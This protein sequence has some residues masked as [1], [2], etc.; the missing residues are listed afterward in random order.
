VVSAFRRIDKHRAV[1]AGSGLV[2]VVAIQLLLNRQLY[3]SPLS[4]GYGESGVLFSASHV[5][6]NAG[7]F[8][9]QA[10]VTFGPILLGGLIIGMTVARRDV[11][12]RV[13]SISVAVTMPY[14]FY[15]PFDHWETL[16]YLLP[17]T[18]LLLVL[19]AAGLMWIAKQPRN[20]HLGRAVAVALVA[21]I[22]LRSEALLRKSS[23]WDI[24]SAEARYPLAGQWL[25][26]NTP[27][28]SVALANQHSGSLR[29]YGN[30]PTLRWDLLA[31]ESLAPMVRELE[32]RG[33]TV[34][35][36]L[37]GAEVEMFERQFAAVLDQLR[38]DHVGRVRNVH[39]RRLS[40]SDR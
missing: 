38:V 27:P 32:G 22:A 14:L 11:L 37:E 13:L 25:N 7:I 8:A 5:S 16:R 28:Q 6:T 1:A 10:W 17:A 36:A 29:W 19:A 18:V 26:V 21:A 39:F 24:Q 9:R 31:P 2:A 20:P 4:T 15:L 34:C 23:V 33:A 12:W 35:V 3:G 30:R 40:I